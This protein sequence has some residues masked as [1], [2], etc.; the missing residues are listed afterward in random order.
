METRNEILKSISIEKSG[1]IKNS[2]SDSIYKFCITNNLNTLYDFMTLYY[3]KRNN[4]DRRYNFSYFDG[5]IDLI[6]LIF[7]K[8][9]LSNAKLLDRKIKIFKNES[10][11]TLFA[12]VEGEIPTIG[13]AENN[14]LKRLGFN[15]NEAKV[16]LRRVLNIGKET[17]IIHAIKSCID[18]FNFKNMSVDDE[19]FITKLHVLYQYYEEHKEYFECLRESENKVNDLYRRMLLI[20][21][22]LIMSY[23]EVEKE[24]KK[25]NLEDEKS[26]TLVRKY[27]QFHCK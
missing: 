7:F 15:N 8:D 24:V 12:Y 11:K 22:T 5:V 2:M 10:P 18:N 25:L 14:T 26:K 1:I 27:R 23:S 20:E 21:R 9:E 4:M 17:S 6:N 3:V 19:M 16:I 13:R